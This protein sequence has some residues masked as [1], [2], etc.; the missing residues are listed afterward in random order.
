MLLDKSVQPFLKWAGGKRQLLPALQSQL[1][2]GYIKS[3]N[4]YYEPFLGG[5]ALLFNLQPKRAVINDVNAELMNCYKVIKNLVDELS[6][7][8][9]IH[10]YEKDY[11]YEIRN[12]DRNIDYKNK[13]PVQRASRFIF[14]NKTCYNGL[15]R[16]NL[17]GQFNVPFGKYKKVNILDVD[18]LKAVS[19]YLNENEINILNIDFQ[20]ATKDA[21]KGDFIYFDPPYDPVSASSDF[22]GYDSRGFGK[23]EQIRL[24]Q[25]FDDLSSRGCKILLS[26][27][28]Y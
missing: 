19:R 16:V 12:L 22:T 23:E 25:T 2:K 18:T 7:D 17:Q 28:Y 27:A 6:E 8:L 13:T 10:K 20:E 4:S 21:E 26:N 9:K 15:Y 14:L 1:P 11:F 24:K 3:D 5:G